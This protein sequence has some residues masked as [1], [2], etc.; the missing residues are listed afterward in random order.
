M[1]DRDS[2]GKV[3]IPPD[4]WVETQECLIKHHRCHFI[5]QGHQGTYF[6]RVPS[7]LV[8]SL[9]DNGGEFNLTI[10]NIATVSIPYVANKAII[11]PLQLS[12]DILEPIKKWENL[13][14]SVLPQDEMLDLLHWN[15]ALVKEQNSEV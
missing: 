14:T 11:P 15:K 2:F 9:T 5:F 4:Y 3:Y 12:I 6:K 1:I 7:G 13:S 8:F 10:V